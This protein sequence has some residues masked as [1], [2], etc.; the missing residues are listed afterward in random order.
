MS[1]I[2]N[3]RSLAYTKVS[4]AEKELEK[5][6]PVFDRYPHTRHLDLNTNTIP[7]LQPVEVLEHLVW[8]NSSKNQINCLNVFQGSSFEQLQVLNLSGNKLK[9]LDTVKLP[10]LRRLNLSENEI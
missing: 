7:D 9:V 4:L 5:L 10:N 2:A 3:N 6:F 1:K 8:L